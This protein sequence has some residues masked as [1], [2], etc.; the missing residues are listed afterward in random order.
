ML[1]TDI[2]GPACVYRTLS[3]S[4]ATVEPKTLTMASVG[5]PISFAFRRAAKVSAV[6]PD[7][8]INIASEFLC[9]G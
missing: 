9:I 6:S 1:A 5:I 3:A 2:S 4:R 8:E 7:C